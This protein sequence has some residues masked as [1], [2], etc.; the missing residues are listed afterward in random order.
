MPGCAGRYDLIVGNPPYVDAETMA[1]LDPEYRHEPRIG[2]EA[3]SDGLDC[4]RRIL[5]EAGGRLR[6]GGV[7]VC[8]V[9]ASPGRAG[10]GFPPR[11][12]FTWLELE[13]GGE[14]VFLLTGAQLAEF[15]GTG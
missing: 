4:V 12:G 14:G 11:T 2:L 7:L 6:S 9:G 1:S 10:A 15:P 3:G 13:R 5:A 8:E